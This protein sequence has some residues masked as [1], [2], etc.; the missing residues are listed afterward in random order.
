MSAKGCCSAGLEPGMCRPEGRR[1]R[2]FNKL[3]VQIPAAKVGES[4][5][6]EVGV[7]AVQCRAQSRVG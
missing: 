4:L 5:L 3:S 7:I 2:S 6:F 1:Y